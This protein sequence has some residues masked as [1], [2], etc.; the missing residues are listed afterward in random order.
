MRLGRLSSMKKGCHDDASTFAESMNV[1]ATGLF[2]ITRAFGDVM[3][4]QRSGSIIN[5]GSI[6]GMVGPDPTIYKGTE[7]SGWFPD[8]FFHKG[9]NVLFLCAGI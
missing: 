4:K 8:Y 5:I 6:Q 7:M 9:G 2:L 3:A 1:N